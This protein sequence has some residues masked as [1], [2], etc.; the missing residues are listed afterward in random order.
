MRQANRP[1]IN[2]MPSAYMRL[3]GG[4]NRNAS[5]MTAYRPAT[6]STPSKGHA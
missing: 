5:T 4:A 3:P 2:K 1:T 6:A